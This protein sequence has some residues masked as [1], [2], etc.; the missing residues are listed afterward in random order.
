MIPSA[1]MYSPS[2][3]TAQIQ[4]IASWFFRGKRG[5]SQLPVLCPLTLTILQSVNGVT[6][7]QNP[8]HIPHVLGTQ[9]PE[10]LSFLE[11]LRA[12]KHTHFAVDTQSRHQDEDPG[13]L[14]CPH[15]ITSSFAAQ[16]WPRYFMI[17]WPKRRSIE[18]WRSSWFV[19]RISWLPALWQAFWEVLLW[20]CDNT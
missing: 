12:R 10:Q 1:K 13:L 9:F 5:H 8:I 19:H 17:Q 3:A 7:L 16:L 18:F 15:H 14:W 2:S 20:N 4:A 6:S 11:T